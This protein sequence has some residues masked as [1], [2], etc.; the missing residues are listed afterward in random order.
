MQRNAARWQHQFWATIQFSNLLKTKNLNLNNFTKLAEFKPQF[1]I[2]IINLSI[3]LLFIKI[4]ISMTKTKPALNQKY[5][6]ELFV[7]EFKMYF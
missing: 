2:I 4:F 6:L 5:F 1:Q 3:C 7:F